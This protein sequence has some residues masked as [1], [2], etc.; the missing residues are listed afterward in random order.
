MTISSCILWRGASRADAFSPANASRL[1]PEPWGFPGSGWLWFT[2]C[3][4]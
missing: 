2:R 4:C 3:F 1:P